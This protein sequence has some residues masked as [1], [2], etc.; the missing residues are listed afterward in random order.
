M[1]L[2]LYSYLGKKPMVK[3]DLKKCTYNDTK[4]HKNLKRRY[5]N[6]GI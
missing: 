3:T 2:T 6:K 1:V 5:H 4:S